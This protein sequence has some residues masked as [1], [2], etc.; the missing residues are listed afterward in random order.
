MKIGLIDVDGH[1]FPN[2]AL[3]KIAKYHKSQ[4][5]TVE[6]AEC[7]K[8]ECQLYFSKSGRGVCWHRGSYFLHGEKVKFKV[9]YI[10]H[11][12]AANHLSE[13]TKQVLHD[14]AKQAYKTK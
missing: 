5:D 4:G 14:V 11:I 6:R 9:P 13:E 2:L 1:N 3:M 12:S 7:K 8:A 10:N